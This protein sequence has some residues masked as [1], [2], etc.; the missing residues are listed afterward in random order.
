MTAS[1][2]RLLAVKTLGYTHT[3]A[4]Y[5]LAGEII[6]EYAEYAEMMREA[7]EATKHDDTYD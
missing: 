2:L 4:G 6:D 7:R 1:R 5:R 3:E